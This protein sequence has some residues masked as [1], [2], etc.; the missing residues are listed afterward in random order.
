MTL[1]FQ[2]IYTTLLYLESYLEKA[3]HMQT[4]SNLQNYLTC[5]WFNIH[6][7]YTQTGACQRDNL[8]TGSALFN[9]LPE[10]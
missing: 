2:N 1:N 5:H 4:N 3:S 9:K 10:S 6:M 7:A 8:N